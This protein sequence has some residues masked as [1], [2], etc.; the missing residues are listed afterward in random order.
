MLKERSPCRL[1]IGYF[2]TLE[3]PLPF[4][5]DALV[6]GYYII[7]SGSITT[8]YT[9]QPLEYLSLPFVFSGVI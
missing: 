1:K 5:P 2:R 6:S 8:P 9:P 7:Q 3:R 4:Q